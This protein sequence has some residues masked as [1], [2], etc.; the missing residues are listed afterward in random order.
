MRWHRSALSMKKQVNIGVCVEHLRGS[1]RRVCEGMAAYAATRPNWHLQMLDSEALD[2]KELRRYDGFIWDVTDRRL[3]RKLGKSGKPVI[4]MVND[5]KYDGTISVGADHAACGQLAARYFIVRKFMSFAFCGWKGLRFSDARG[6]AFAHALN[7]NRFACERY[8]SDSNG[9]K[10]FVR[11]N[12]FKEQLKLPDDAP[13][14]LRWLRKLRTP[15]GLFCANDLRAWQVAEIC[16]R[17]RI[18]VPN[19]IAI[20]GADND[21]LVCSFSSPSI[22]SVDTAAFRIGYIAVETLA[23]VVEGRV[24]ADRVREV[25]VPPLEIESRGSSEV[26]P[27]EPGWLADALVFIRANVVKG[28]TA[29]DVVKHVGLSYSTVEGAFRQVLGLTIQK[30]I[31][32]TRLD[33]A[34]HMLK[35]TSLSL[36][37]IAKRAG[38]RSQQYFNKCFFGR[39]GVSPGGWRTGL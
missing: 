10:T 16:R 29:D 12:V 13:S 3:A 20:L 31:M 6:S 4:D 35:A 32:A 37:E 22:S 30:E 33:Y 7:L 17:N 21:T 11:E 24:R 18:S 8:V 27:V 14:I 2:E 9:M 26:F 5:G 25:K 38:F 36:S 15:C 28:L 19:E 34:E 23:S 1:G 39:H